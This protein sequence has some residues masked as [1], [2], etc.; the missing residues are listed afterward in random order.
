MA[1]VLHPGSA[2]PAA[3]PSDSARAADPAGF[4]THHGV[5]AP[6]VK[7]F[8][9]VGFRF[10]AAIISVCFLVPLLLVGGAWFSGVNADIGFAQKEREGV[11]FAREVMPLQALLVRQ[12]AL[13]AQQTALGQA[14]AELAAVQGEVA[15]QLKA[16]EAAQAA[17]GDA[18]A[19]AKALATLKQT[20][21]ALPA[22]GELEAVMAAHNTA[23]AAA[24]DLVTQATDGSNL[25]LDPV[26]DTYY[27][28]DGALLR[29]PALLDRLGRLSAL[30]GAIAGGAQT[31]SKAHD[32]MVRS[33]FSA[34]MLTSQVDDALRKVDGVHPGTLAALRVGELDAALKAFRLE[35]QAMNNAAKI[36]ANGA[37]VS[38]DVVALQRAMLE[39]LDVLLGERVA[40][41]RGRGIA[42]GVAVA[43]FVAV[44]GYLFYSFYL[45]MDGGLKETRRHLRAMTDGDL[46]TSPDPW[47]R[48]EAAQLMVALRA[49]QDS[50]R[51]IVTEVRTG[52]DQIL[53]SS[54]EIASGAMDLSARTEKTAANLEE[55]VASMEEISGTVK[56]TA[57]NAN[58]A[59]TIARDNATAATE[60]GRT[61][62]QV[63]Q[64][65]GGIGDSSRRIGEIIGVI[66]G[67]AFQTNILA[68]N[69][70]VEAARAGDAG[71][72]FAVVASE[73]RA[74][75]Q[76][77]G[78]AAREIK[79]L[80]TTSVEQVQAGT[81]VVGQAREAIDRV[82]DSAQ[83]V[84]GLIDEI[85]TAAR[86]QALGVEQVG[87][88]ATEL[89]Q[90]T[91]ANAALVEQTA[92][93]AQA[94]REQAAQLAQRVSRFR[95]PD[96]NAPAAAPAA[97]AAVAD[98]DL[99]KAV[100]AHRAWKVK[101]R[102]AIAQREQLDADAICRD[103]RCPL[104]QW[105][106]GPGGTR[107]GARPAFVALLDEHAE[108]HRAAGEV[109][110][111]INRGA[112]DQ[113]ERLLGSG[114]HFAEASNRTVTAI[115]R[116]KRDL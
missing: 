54:S 116:V 108:F 95:L 80:I 89:D 20:L 37:K 8:R 110:A 73:V 5:W 99:D 61:M 27:L 105:L 35:A 67:I 11:A 92:A 50:L 48:D 38:D 36:T 42:M 69:A 14:P 59:V 1:A 28:M 62:A 68:L 7:L 71:R 91:Q 82:V 12:R 39:R 46:T 76:R 115:L 9:Q 4:F 15:R 13:A 94:L 44:A 34:E 21:A 84:G 60:G 6:G 64:T 83:R 70:A 63:V 98:F 19:T 104:G 77:S 57:D 85:A 102:S 17:S 10:K 75:A 25:T 79:A 112:Y 41:L 109:A 33:E 22:G 53:H 32:A 24:V 51:T 87:A 72:G 3:S 113:A 86:E 31:S 96:G 40:T 16:V 111:T 23:V 29:I 93:A 100:D 26:I 103:D 90:T 55:T 45:V 56:S 74:L 52:S 30:G 58:A 43:L 107:W 65:M 106:H 81:A 78:A 66:D 114:S 47:G 18:F 49:M 2:T 101:L 97:A 88:A